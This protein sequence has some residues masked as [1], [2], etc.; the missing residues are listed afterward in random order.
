M[1][2]K[3]FNSIS[4]IKDT[5]TPDAL[6]VLKDGTARWLEL[7]NDFR[8]LY[9]ANPGGIQAVDLAHVKSVEFPDSGK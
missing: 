6:F 4:A 2:A 3:P 5:T 1:I 7:I 9:L 8:V